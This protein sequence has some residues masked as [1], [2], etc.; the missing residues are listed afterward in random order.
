MKIDKSR[1]KKGWIGL[2]E[3]DDYGHLEESMSFKNLESL[4][5][6]AK[7]IIEKINKF[8]NEN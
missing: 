8:K 2:F 3:E 7:E 1:E 4:Q 5:E 6:Y